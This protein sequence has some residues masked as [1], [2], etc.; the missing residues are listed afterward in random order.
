MT[1]VAYRC[2][3]FNETFT[4]ACFGLRAPA[5]VQLAAAGPGGGASLAGGSQRGRADGEMQLVYYVGVARESSIVLDFGRHRKV[6][7]QVVT[8]VLPHVPSLVS[9]YS[10]VRTPVHRPCSQSLGE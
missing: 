3:R 10:L 2:L 4:P 6:L 7:A 8:G 5:G 1:A 9:R